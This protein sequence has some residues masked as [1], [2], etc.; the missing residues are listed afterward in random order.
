[1]APKVVISHDSLVDWLSKLGIA[2]ALTKS[3]ALLYEVLMIIK[4]LL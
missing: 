3:G 1:M 4:E 2:C